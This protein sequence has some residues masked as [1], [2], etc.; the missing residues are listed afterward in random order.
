MAGQKRE[1]EVER[2]RYERQQARRAQRSEKTK[3]RERIIATVVVAVLA[4]GGFAYLGTVLNND[5]AVVAD[6]STSPTPSTEPSPSTSVE[7]STMDCAAP[8]G[9]TPGAKTYA[10]APDVTLKPDTT[11]SVTLATNC[12]DIV[13]ELDSKGAPANV[14]SFLGLADDGYFDDTMCHRLTTENIFV[15][16]CGD[17][18]GDGTGGPGFTLP[19]E[20]LP[21]DED[22]NYPAGTVAM[23]NA[24]ANIA[25]SQF[26]LVYK[27]TTLPPNYTILGTM[28]SGLKLVEAGGRAGHRRRQPATGR[29]TSRSRSSRRPRLRPRPAADMTEQ[30]TDDVR[31][32]PADVQAAVPTTVA[33]VSNRAVA[34]RPSSNRS[35]RR[36]EPS[37]NRPS[38]TRSCSS[39]T[40]P[41]L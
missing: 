4:V 41:S 35:R 2:A 16:Q 15:L 13:I 10:E 14:E 26:F 11:Y 38:L 33:V 36:T 32:E 28:T 22:N 19:D 37:S 9:E 3:R 31:S 21:K 39:R 34:D 7:P 17:P 6:P 23:A 20:N 25:G 18:V 30:P 40:P 29:R 8:N 5:D 1:R 27:D 12:G 24:G